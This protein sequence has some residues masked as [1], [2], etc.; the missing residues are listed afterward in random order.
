ME[1]AAADR[2]QVVAPFMAD[3]LRWPSDEIVSR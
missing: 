3:V 1:A 2:G